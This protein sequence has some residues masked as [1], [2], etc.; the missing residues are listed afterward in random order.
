MKT[1][2]TLSTN[3]KK[4]NHEEQL[5]VK[6]GICPPFIHWEGNG[7]SAVELSTDGTL[8][9]IWIG[10]FYSGSYSTDLFDQ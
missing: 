2:K 1:L 8:Y 5:A 4:L 9:H 7:Y 3:I 6:G 10:G